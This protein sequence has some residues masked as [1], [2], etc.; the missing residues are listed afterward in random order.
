MNNTSTGAVS[1]VAEE[2]EANRET[3]WK[4]GCECHQKLIQA[5]QTAMVCIILILERK[6]LRHRETDT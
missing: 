5:V 4:G 2:A 1:V 6:K 3:F